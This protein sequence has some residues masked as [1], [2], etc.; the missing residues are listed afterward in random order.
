MKKLVRLFAV[1]ALAGILRRRITA[2]KDR[3]PAG[4]I[5]RVTGVRCTNE[6]EQDQKR[7]FAFHLGRFVGIRA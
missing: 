5:L 4:D 6:K 3:G 7:E 2:N 1:P